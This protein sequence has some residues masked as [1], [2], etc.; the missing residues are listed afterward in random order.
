MAEYQNRWGQAQPATRTAG[1]QAIDEGLR[2]YMLRVYNY[3]G[4][5][6]AFTA[7]VTLLMMN[8]PQL[9]VS[10]ATGPMK[11]VLFAGVLGLGFFAPKLIYS[12]SAAMAQ[13]AYWLYAA[14]WGLLISPMIFA[15]FKVGAGHLVFRALALTAVTFGA[16]SLFGYITKRDLSGWGQFLMMATIGI[17]VVMLGHALFAWM[18][19]ID[20]GTSKMMS[21]VISC[22][23]VLLFSAITAYETQEIKNMYYMGDEATVRRSAIFGAFMLYGSFITLFIHILNIM[24][25]MRDE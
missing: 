10:V 12:G 17:L 20:A 7:I 6:V 1:A 14:L 15:F 11:W 24:G 21:L 23:V 25:I 13:G 9:M 8:N 4:M 16:T 19:W 3:M 2:S 5:G 18:G 22:V